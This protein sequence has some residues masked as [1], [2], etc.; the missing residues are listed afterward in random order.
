VKRAYVIVTDNTAYVAAEL[1]NNFE[2]KL[3]R[4]VENRIAD[5]VRKTDASIDN[6][7]VSTNPDFINRMNNFVNDIGEGRPIR[8]LL[9]EF[10]ETVRRIFPNAR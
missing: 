3:T 1:E 2:G 7:Y 6:V 8:G 4:E 5:V 10:T 9:D